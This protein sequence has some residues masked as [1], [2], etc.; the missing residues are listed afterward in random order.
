M[1]DMTL[2]RIGIAVAMSLL[3]GAIIYFGRGRKNGQGRRVPR[4]DAGAAESRTEPSLGDQF[5]D[6]S[7]EI[8]WPVV[9]KPFR[10][11]QLSAAVREALT[12]VTP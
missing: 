9:R 6:G 1:S 3:L 2:L 10:A 8:A 12:R 4:E 11:E 5:A 7:E